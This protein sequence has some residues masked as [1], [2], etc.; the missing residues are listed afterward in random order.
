M[1]GLP[2][3]LV[4]FSLVGL[5]FFGYRLVTDP[6]GLVFHAG[7]AAICLLVLVRNGRLLSKLRIGA[8]AEARAIGCGRRGEAD[9]ASVRG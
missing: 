5:V 2:I 7:G 1:S 6:A 3:A 9:H 4:V 8:Q